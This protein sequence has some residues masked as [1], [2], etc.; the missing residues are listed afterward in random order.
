M[1]SHTYIGIDINDHEK[2][3]EA[4]DVFKKILIVTILTSLSRL[5]MANNQKQSNGT[6]RCLSLAF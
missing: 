6:Y 3:E 4:N 2:L 5:E 1:S